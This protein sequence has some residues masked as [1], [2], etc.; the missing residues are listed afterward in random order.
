MLSVHRPESL[1]LPLGRDSVENMRIG[2]LASFEFCRLAF[3]QRPDHG[4][5]QKGLVLLIVLS[6]EAE[7]LT[8][9]QWLPTVATTSNQ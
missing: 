7:D 6:T 3:R 8:L 5:T 9:A 2:R 4:W 1:R